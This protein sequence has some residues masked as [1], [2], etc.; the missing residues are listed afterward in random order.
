MS[1]P[2]CVEI[3]LPADRTPAQWCNPSPLHQSYY[4]WM[5]GAV[6]TAEDLRFCMPG[7][8]HIGHSYS[9]PSRPWP[10]DAQ[11]RDLSW[12]RNNAF[13]SYKSYFTVGEYEHFFGGYWHAAAFGFGH[14]ARYDDMPGRKVWIWGLSRQGA[15]WEDLLTDTD[16]KYTECLT[17]EPQH[18]QA[19]CR[20]AEFRMRRDVWE[21]P[22]RE[23][24]MV[25]APWISLMP[26]KPP[27]M[28]SDLYQRN[29]YVNPLR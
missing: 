24:V 20:I 27:L 8:F 25:I 3:F 15:I 19:L 6:H 26:A 4:A 18:L 28:I 14:Y 9:V 16:G 17:Q 5:K 22:P 7:R 10:L 11:G 21:T 13:G 12:Y 23:C 1:G 29:R 2:W